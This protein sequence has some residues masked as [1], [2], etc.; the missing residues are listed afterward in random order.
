M[1]ALPTIAMTEQQI[2]DF[3]TEALGPN[4]PFTL[5]QLATLL[6]VLAIA[7]MLL[8][9]GLGYQAAKLDRRVKALEAAQGLAAP[10][11]CRIARADSAKEVR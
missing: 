11:A 7:T 9:M 2:V 4:A 5:E 10:A 6:F 8:A 1:N 3:M